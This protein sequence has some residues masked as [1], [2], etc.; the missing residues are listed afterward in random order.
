MTKL[1]N[2]Q[3]LRLKKLW[4]QLLSCVHRS[5]R[6]SDG[7][8]M[9]MYFLGR[10]MMQI[11]FFPYCPGCIETLLCSHWKLYMWSCA[12][13]SNSEGGLSDWITTRLWH[14]L[15]L[16]H[17]C[18]WCRWGNIHLCNKD[19]HKNLTKTIPIIE[20]ELF[21]SIMSSSTRCDM[22]VK[23]RVVL[24][25]Q[26]STE[27]PTFFT[28]SKWYNSSYTRHISCLGINWGRGG[29]V[30]WIVDL[31]SYKWSLFIFC[32]FCTTIFQWL[33]FTY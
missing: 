7:L 19:T 26:D 15:Q 5:V 14:A 24:R 3:E 18:T 27:N 9:I 31:F 1:I 29:A 32:S 30:I 2:D 6:F 23:S 20:A 25:L 17:T 4:K 13:Q 16:V 22:N 21:T 8:A 12:S 28:F 33:V 11:R 10:T